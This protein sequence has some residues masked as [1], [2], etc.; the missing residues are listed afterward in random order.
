MSEATGGAMR[1]APDA[2]LRR[3]RLVPLIVIEDA[4]R[5]G[6]LGNALA[7]GGLPI[8]EVAFRTP[9]ARESLARMAGECPDVLVGAGTVLSVEQVIDAQ[10]AG[11]RFIVAPGLNARV[12]ERCQEFGLPVFPGVCTPTEVEAALELGLTTLKF[13]PAEP[14]GGLPFLQAIAAPYRDVDFIPTGGITAA[15]LPSYLAFSRVAACGGSWMAPAAWI[16]SGAFDKVS[17]AAREAVA[18]VHAHTP[19]R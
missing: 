2:L 4:A 16:A 15:N 19:Q 11:A 6:A 5:A 13:F 14:M 8:A 9:A 10:R 12:V 17:A 1:D 18:L 7:A 3:V